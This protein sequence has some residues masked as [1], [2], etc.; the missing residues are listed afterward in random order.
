MDSTTLRTRQGPLKQSYRDDPAKALVLSRI[1]ARLEPASI[2]VT[3]PV[4][5][6]LQAGLH[7]STGGTD[8]F[9]CSADMLL[10]SLA[11]CAGVTLLAVAAS[12]G[13]VLAGGTIRAAAVWDA[14]GTLGLSRSVPVGIQSISLEFA[15]EGAID[16]ADRERLLATTE[17]Y[18]V[19]LA[20]L[21]DGPRVSVTLA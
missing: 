1:E 4:A 18:C 13:I 21:R 6:P 12:M 15:L 9:A 10:E 5:R 20:T 8:G 3:F 16:E 17:R 2:A 14:R 7:P 11:A 19:I